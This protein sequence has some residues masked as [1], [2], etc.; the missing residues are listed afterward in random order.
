M[1]NTRM[2]MYPPVRVIVCLAPALFVKHDMLVTLSTTRL[3]V[4][5]RRIIHM[6]SFDA[7]WPSGAFS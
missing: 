2:Y 4:M 3:D 7:Y 6:V 5:K 1:Y